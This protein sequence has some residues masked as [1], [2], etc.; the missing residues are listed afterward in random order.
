MAIYPGLRDCGGGLGVAEI[1]KLA[2]GSRG[3][4]FDKNRVVKA[5]V[6]EGIAF[7]KYALD[8][9]SCHDGG[10][11]GFDSEGIMAMDLFGTGAPVCDRQECTNTICTA[12]V[13]NLTIL[14]RRAG[15]TRWMAP[16]F[17]WIGIIMVKVP[18][19]RTKI[20]STLHRIEL[21]FCPWKS[22]TI[23]GSATYNHRTDNL[24]AFCG[25][26]YSF[27]GA[28]DRIQKGVARILPCL[29]ADVN[30]GVNIV[31]DLDDESVIFECCHG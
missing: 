3:R 11:K 28:A 24:D 30:V 7:L 4:H 25:L 8:F 18:N 9:V 10:E 21:E 31:G 16:F 20:E 29:F 23:R 1:E 2:E 26:M 5:E 12:M 27:N 13:N 6:V 22:K 19:Q 14:M 17:S 15:L